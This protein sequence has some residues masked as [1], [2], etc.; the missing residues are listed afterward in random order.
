[1]H[2]EIPGLLYN[3]SVKGGLLECHISNVHFVILGF[4]SLKI[5]A[6]S[7]QIELSLE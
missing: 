3:I 4:N 7:G 5:G 1:M 6:G 2:V